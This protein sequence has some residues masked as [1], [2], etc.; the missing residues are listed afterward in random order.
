[1]RDETRFAATG[2][3]FDQ[4]RQALAKGV[5]EKCNFIASGFVK[6]EFVHLSEIQ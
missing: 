6:R 2:R 1:M 4:Q 5:L 3:P